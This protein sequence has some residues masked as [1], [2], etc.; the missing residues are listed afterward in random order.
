[1]PVIAAALF[2]AFGIGHR[3]FHAAKSSSVSFALLSGGS[4]GGKGSGPAAAEPRQVD[5]LAHDLAHERLLFFHMLIGV[6]HHEFEFAGHRQVLLQNAALEDAKTFV[7]IGREPQ[8]HARLEKFQLR[9]AFQNAV[10]RHLQVRLEKEHDVRQRGEIVDAAHPVR[11][12]TAHHVARERGENIAV[13]Q[14]DVAGAQQRQQMAFVTVGEIRRV[15]EA[16]RRRRQQLALFAL[17][18]GG[19]HQLGGIPLAEIDLDALGFEPA[20]EQI[21]LRG[22]A[23]PVEAL[24]GDEPPGEIQ[25]GK[26]FHHS[27]STRILRFLIL[28]KRPPVTSASC[29]T[30]T[31]TG[32]VKFR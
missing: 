10:E 7:G 25:F 15:N 8:I 9:A 23:R 22:L 27:R 24:D 32:F 5:P 11:R 16:E 14:H 29:S 20:L 3:F 21:N 28:R 30:P 31:A 2:G 18:G 19:F 17:A 12:T 26:S 6:H 4:G 1:M 13:A